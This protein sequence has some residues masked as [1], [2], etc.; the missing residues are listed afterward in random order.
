MEILVTT[1]EKSIW[2]FQCDMNV[3]HENC[4]RCERDHGHDHGLIGIVYFTHSYE[5]WKNEKFSTKKMKNFLQAPSK[6]IFPY[7]IR[8]IFF[9]SKK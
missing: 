3:C 6:F 1:I 9:I 4:N 8:L 5:K 7:E 2:V